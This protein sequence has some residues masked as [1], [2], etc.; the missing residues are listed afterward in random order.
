MTDRSFR[1]ENST[2]VRATPDEVRRLLADP[3]TWSQWQPEI[4][5]A[6]GPSPMERGDVARGE[7]DMLGFE[8]HGHTEALDV[9]DE[10]FE[11]DVIVGVRMVVRY[12]V[13]ASPTGT[14]VTHRLT[15]QLPGGLSGRILSL[16]LRPRLRALQR[17]VLERIARQAGPS[18]S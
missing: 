2:Q 5:S 8:V 17:G 10:V 16:F 7:A 11:E 9:T 18:S 15:A 12:E 3:S 14:R 1:I 6:S 4:I 13:S